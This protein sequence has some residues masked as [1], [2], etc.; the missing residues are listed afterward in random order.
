[1]TH[2]A[3]LDVASLPLTGRHLIE[4]SAG[5]GKTFNITRL[6]LRLMLEKSFNV[7]Q[8]LVMT[9]TK[10]ATEEI[11]GRLAATLE[12]AIAYWQARM[13]GSEPQ[14]R[15]P[16]YAALY[17]ADE[18]AAA[19]TKLK[20]AQLEMDEA[21]VYTIH[22]FC[23]HVLN[24]LSFES[25]AA[26]QLTLD[27]D[28]A[29]LY[30]QAAEDWIRAMSADEEAYTLLAE[31]GW[32][33]PTQLLDTFG[34]AIRG[35]LTP[36]VLDEHAIE[37]DAGKQQLALASAMAPRFT[38]VRQTMLENEAFILDT[39]VYGHKDEVKRTEEWAILLNYLANADIAAPPSEAKQFIN[40]NRYRGKDE[41]KALF[42][43]LKALFDE[44]AKAHSG[45]IKSVEQAREQTAVLKRVAGAFA[46]IRDHVEAQKR[47]R[48]LIDF[49][50][51]I[52]RLA[53]EATNPDSVVA[54]TLRQRFPAALIDEFQDT[55][56]AQYA[57]VDA[58]YPKDDEKQVLMMIGDP[59]QAI[60]GFRG[61]D[62]FTYL[63][64]G[65]EADYRWVM[66]TNWRSVADMVTAYNRLF[67]GA[68]LAEPH[69]DVFGY[70]IDYQQVR[71]TSA[72]KATKTPLSDPDP[73]R[74]ALTYLQLDAEDQA[75]KA[76]LQQPLSCWVGQEIHRLLREARLG[77]RA[78]AP[79][80]IA[81]LVRSAN[82]AVI[83]QRALQNVGLGAVFLSNKRSLFASGQAQDV[84][85]LL[86]GIW[87][88]DST[89]TL[90]ACLAS[91]LLGFSHQQ[92]V[93][94]LHQ[95]D[96]VLWDELMELIALLKQMWQQ[97]GCMTVILYL[98][99]HRYL[100]GSSEP[101]R[102][103]TNYLHLAEVLGREAATHARA[104]QLLLWLHRQ[105]AD[106][107][108]GDELVQR[109]ESDDTLIQ[110]VTQHG[111]KGLEYP[112]VFVPF[113]NDYRD[114]AKAGNQTAQQFQYYDEHEGGL[115]LQLGRSF[116]AIERVQAEGEAEA[117]RLLYVAVTRA[118]QR[119]Y[120]G[121]A[122]FKQ[123]QK[124]PLARALGYTGSDENALSG[125]IDRVIAE[126]EGHTAAI[127]F[128]ECD[129]L[130]RGRITPHD[131]VTPQVVDFTGSVED[132]WRLYSFSMLAR[133]QSVVKQTVRDAEATDA[134]LV[135]A[136]LADEKEQ[137]A[138]RF[139]FEKGARAGNLLHDILE[140]ADFTEPDWSAASAGPAARFGLP[141]D[142]SA[143][144]FDWLEDVLAA[145]LDASGRLTLAQLP[146][147]ATLREAEFYFP[148]DNLHMAGLNALLSEHRKSLA[149]LCEPIAVTDVGR[150]ELDGMMHGFIDLIFEA[151]GRFYVADYKSTWLG[152]SHADY[153]PGA[154]CQNN[155]QH[156][157]DL[158]YLI[159]A[160]ALHRYLAQTLHDYDPSRHFGGVYYLYLRGMTAASKQQEGVF[161]TAISPAMLDALDRLFDNTEQVARESLT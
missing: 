146:L 8:I 143:P 149:S 56:A 63:K 22:G 131:E 16:V 38:E 34:K 24:L 152:Y 132:A 121:V 32:H 136:R 70:G 81:I 82:E 148:V 114:P 109:L 87:H 125:A 97:R 128:R 134:P 147:S 91:P 9:F 157:Y 139:T 112:I 61:G 90:S 10:A 57:I 55:D 119:C 77:E 113:G 142:A 40:G 155:Q 6:Y 154:L 75:T 69:A 117:M 60:Y 122:P 59:K 13:A 138:F 72:A 96:D 95:D 151:E 158:Q 102:E 44:V 29:E 43:P 118:A 111:S 100:P 156:L 92:I 52:R 41:I 58:V 105:L 54:E 28:T 21:S 106:P 14:Q 126:G 74:A 110:I 27:T 48:N 3:H 84:Y 51:L 89:S 85:R 2:S 68:P 130:I 73:G 42:M 115:V 46:F 12:E 67:H 133:Q 101:E 23:Q 129:A 45:H 161:Y 39:L 15:D 124:S 76:Q 144:L 31:Q 25:G 19:L 35:N 103:L 94:L 140:L 141:D 53:D 49:D 5:T 123:H 80:D 18:P 30:Q 135:A 7:Q 47:Q 11:R 66:D 159:Y 20:A 78:V 33:V 137:A 99:Q 153:H 127:R 83:M 120:I 26:M 86:D 93:D 104:D 116:D 108:R 88:A 50:D 150:R 4:A 65:R 79:S 98:M 62:I 107:E 64:A 37:Q 71:S 17:D 1:M 36:Q 145:P 160:L